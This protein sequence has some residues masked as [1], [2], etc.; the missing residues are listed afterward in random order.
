VFD[1]VIQ[2]GNGTQWYINQDNF[3]RSVRN[4]VI[5]LR[6]MPVSAT[7]TGLHWQVS[8][9]TSLM[10]IVVE[11]SRDPESNH[12]GNVIYCYICLGT[13]EY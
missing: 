5:D 4:V 1:I 12:Q 2:K 8:Q 6:Q 7:A 11:M 10:N 3:F 13:P 9:A